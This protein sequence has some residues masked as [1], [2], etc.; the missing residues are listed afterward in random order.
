[1]FCVYLQSIRIDEI[2]TF[3]KNSAQSPSEPSTGC[4]YNHLLTITGGMDFVLPVF[5]FLRHRKE[6]NL[7]KIVLSTKELLNL[8]L[9][10]ISDEI[11]K[12]RHFPSRHVHSE[13]HC[14]KCCARVEDSLGHLYGGIRHLFDF[15]VTCV[16][17]DNF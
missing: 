16:L 3:S 1:M 12:I 6:I 11:R 4:E 8:L 17:G 13:G 2:S 7:S 15:V 14:C 9:P 5:I 10:Q